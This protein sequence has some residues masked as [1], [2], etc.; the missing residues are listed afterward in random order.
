MDE[1]ENWFRIIK[2]INCFI[3]K[4]GEILIKIIVEWVLK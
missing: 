3:G 4:H 1:G 2:I